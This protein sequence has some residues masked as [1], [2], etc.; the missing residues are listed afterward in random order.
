MDMVIVD[1]AV[2]QELHS[3]ILRFLVHFSQETAFLCRSTSKLLQKSIR[4][5]SKKMLREPL[6]INTFQGGSLYAV[7]FTKFKS[8]LTTASTNYTK[9]ILALH[10]IRKVILP[11]IEKSPSKNTYS[12]EYPS[13]LV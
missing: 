5:I 2:Y 13:H 10:K 3:Y 6:I 4:Q 7:I 1:H 12:P 9:F 11:E 8:N